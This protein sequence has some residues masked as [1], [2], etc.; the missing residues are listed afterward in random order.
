MFDIIIG[1]SEEDRKKYGTKGA[2]LLAKHYV[3]MGQSTSL[4][5]NVYMD[6]TRSHVVFV[7]GKR[8]GGKCVTGDTLITLEDGS[9]IPIENIEYLD[10]KILALNENLKISLNPKEGFYKRNVDETIKITLRTGKTIRLTPEHPLLTVEGW[11]NAEDL[12]QNERIATPREIKAFGDNYIEEHKIKI[13]A[14]LLAEGHLR[15]NFVLFSNTDEEIVADF[16]QAIKTFDKNL[17][18]KKH[19]RDSDYRIVENKKKTRQIVTRNNLSQIMTSIPDNAKSSI[20]NWLDEIKMYGHLSN[21]KEIPDFVFTATKSNIALLL[22][23]MFSCDGTIYKENSRWRISYCTNSWKMANQ[24][25]SLL[26]RFGVVSKIREKKTKKEIEIYAGFIDKFIQEIGFVGKKEIKSKIAIKENISITRNTNVDT[27]PKKI[28]DSFNPENWSEIGR[29]LN[30]KYPKSAQESIRYS[31]SRQ[32]LLQIAKIT[33]D[34]YLST[35]AESDIF[36]DEITQI[37]KIKEPI[38]VYDITVPTNHNFVANNIIIHNS[39]TLGVIAEG[40]SDLPK[41]VRNNLSIVLVDTMG[42]YWTM[43]YPNKKDD[44]LLKQWGLEPK[45]LD[46]KI[47]TPKAF[48]QEYKDKGIPTDVAFTIAVSELSGTDWCTTFEYNEN[49]KYGVLIDKVIND[50]KDS[51]KN[52]DIDDIIKKIE[53]D[54]TSEVFVKAAVKNHFVNAKTWGL[55]EKEG[56]YLKDIVKG[57]QVTVLDVSCY[58]TMP[59]GWNIKSLVLGLTSQKLFEQRMKA[60]KDEEFEQINETVHFFGQREEQK[61]KREPLVWLVVDEAHEFLPNKGKTTSSGPL[62][63]ILR[64]GR[65]PGISL[66]LATQQPGKIHTD[67]MTQSDTVLSHRITAKIDVDALSA[68]MQ[69]YMRK[70]LDDELDNLPRSKGAAVIFDDTNEKMYPIRVRPR[71]TWHGGESPT[72]MQEHKDLEDL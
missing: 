10:K 8:G 47:Y 3:K 15:N 40:L 71:F 65:Q 38:M 53:E 63:T 59:N 44:E 22:N 55:F 57:G 60:R 39:Y 17:I 70:G 66:I 28:W 35:L 72:A 67:V 62:I 64:E 45:G 21:T 18:I 32:K 34:E 54:D 61:V 1:R 24:I 69:S 29:G 6:I 46:V 23:R 27:I 51:G 19:S 11:K 37:E 48:Y 33:E 13:I 26:L 14:Y 30:Y 52:Y 9:E 12:T 7:C 20:R 50:L 56:T 25:Q 49:D 41:E 31:P 68:L 42:I 58:A 5:N 2:V 4:S 43:K 36:W 16:K